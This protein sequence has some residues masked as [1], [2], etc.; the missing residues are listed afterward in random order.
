MGLVLTA[1]LGAIATAV[2][3]AV[4]VAWVEIRRHDLQ[5]A[6]RDKD[7]EEWIVVRQR[8]LKSRLHE[9]KQQATA[10]GVAR[11]GTL[12]T[13]RIAVQTLLLYDYRE[14]LR[15]A[16]SFVLRVAV[17]ERL[18]HRV[19]RYLM[20]WPFPGLTTPDRAERLVDSWSEGTA[21]N[22]LTWSLDDILGE[23]PERA[24]SQALG[25]EPA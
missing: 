6:E 3:G 18:I 20:R 24:T 16:R 2:V 8:E 14:E 11:G 5:V 10:Q 21:R 15:Q 22:T 1:I 23:L 7:I 13:A 12:P 4:R 17:E 25:G 19:L 9:I